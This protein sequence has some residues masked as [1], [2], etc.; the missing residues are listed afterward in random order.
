MIAASQHSTKTDSVVSVAFPVAVAGIYDYAVPPRLLGRI[1]PGMP[2]LVSLRSR[3]M[4]G[5][6]VDLKAAS[7]HPDLKEVMDIKNDNWND[8]GDTLISLYRWVADYYQCDLGRVFRPLLR[9]G[10]MNSAAKTVQTYTLPNDVDCDVGL[11]EKYRLICSKLRQMG[12]FSAAEAMEQFGIP[13]SAIDYLSKK[14]LLVRGSRTV[15]RRANELNA[16]FE[17]QHVI[18]TE[19]Q[20]TAVATI[21][22]EFDS[23]KRPFL[24]HGIT[25][26]GKTHV[27]IELASKV[28]ELGRN[29]IIMV[30]EIA[31][32]PQTIR[33]FKSALGDVV[34]V[35]HSHMSDGERRDSL[36]ELVTGA[37]RVVIGVR[38]AVMAP[39]SNPGLIIV[40][41]EH[42]GSYKQ[43]DLE[44]RYHARDVAVMRGRLQNALVVLGSAT[45]SLESYQNAL[46]GKYVMLRLLERFGPAT[47]P[48]VRI[49][50]MRNEH[51]CNNWQPLSRALIDAIS[52]TVQNNR[53][54]ILLLNRRGFSTM[55][56]CRECG[57]TLHCPNCSVTLRYHR[58]DT[59]LKCHICGY[60]QDAPDC[61]PKCGGHAIK[62]KGT[63]IQKIEEFLTETFPGVRILRMDQDT[64]RRKG[65]HATI[66]QKFADQEADIL[67]G[68]QM[69]SK[70]LD[71][72]NVALVGVVA[73]DTGLH[74][75]DFRASERTFQL[76]TQVSGRAGR[77]DSCGEVIIQT[78]SPEDYA[79]KYAAAHD[80]TGYFGIENDNRRQLGYP[81][82]GRLVRITV[83][84]RSEKDVTTLISGI[85]ARI[86]S[87]A[88]KSITLLGPSPAVLE[89][90][91][92]ESRYTILLKS[93]TAAHLGALLRD[94]RTKFRKIPAELN[95]IIDVDP[96]NM[97]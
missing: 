47:L 95:M 92:N 48:T 94:L 23:P 80:Y 38:S 25:G 36:E 18:L 1:T 12:T 77:S 74:L 93:P 67:L 78:Y 63:G 2:V 72:P 68:T 50:D 87:V 65:A 53:Q 40:D 66:L 45:P 26:S 35:I 71:F 34:T 57:Y 91:N 21:I 52:S 30:P 56:L 89:R 70:G 90:M 61:C 96:V 22:K 41:E 27:Y 11:N 75:P 6:A 58:A 9:K 33:R 14:N 13:R 10:L 15:L 86:R 85:A 97:L 31:L 49:A 73:A 16:E 55:L 19:E 69:V 82:W 88:D 59:A 24:L 81:P 7:D 32:T 44:P 8:S 29:V 37:K 54:I 84:G 4:W 39:L 76:L 5:V 28:L 64:T 17:A 62:Y 79:I 83:Q 46:T 60:R 51:E 20:R 43:S 3:K 42:D